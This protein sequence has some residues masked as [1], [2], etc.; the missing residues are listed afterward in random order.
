MVIAGSIENTECNIHIPHVHV[1]EPRRCCM[2]PRMQDTA[3]LFP[4][5]APSFFSDTKAV[6]LAPAAGCHSHECVSTVDAAAR[7]VWTDWDRL[8]ARAKVPDFPA[9]LEAGK[10]AT[11]GHCRCGSCWEHCTQLTCSSHRRVAGWGCVCAATNA[12]PAEM[13]VSSGYTPP[14]F[15]TLHQSACHD[16]NIVLYACTHQMSR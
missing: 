12:K 6:E 4:A 2:P 16:R 1:T 10:R 11:Y 15:S 9:P 5:M 7:A 13:S 3:N 8:G 14:T